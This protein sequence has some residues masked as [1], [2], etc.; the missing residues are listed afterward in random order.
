MYA[1]RPED[2][3][4]NSDPDTDN[5][6][7][8]QWDRLPSASMR[9]EELA[10]IQAIEDVDMEEEDDYLGQPLAIFPLDAHVDV[11]REYSSV[12]GDTH[13]G[14]ARAYHVIV[15][16]LL[17]LDDADGRVSTR[18]RNTARCEV[19]MRVEHGRRPQRASSTVG[20]RG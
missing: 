9:E 2:S 17:K 4:E 1:P 14:R 20:R 7:G 10:Q 12:T 15:R 3:E 13:S 5:S 19:A 16:A 11:R 8:G 18:E 6:Y